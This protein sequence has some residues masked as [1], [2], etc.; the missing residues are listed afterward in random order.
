MELLIVRHGETIWNAKGLL[1]GQ[2]DIELNEN[3]IAAAKKLG[4]ELKDLKID[5]FFASPLKRA[6]ETAR[7][8]KG[9]R[10]L[11]IETD[12]R[13]KEISFGKAEGVDYHDWKEPGNKYYPFFEDTANYIP[14]EDGETFDDIIKRTTEFIKERIEP[15]HKTCERVLL[16]AHG[17]LNKGMMCYLEN[18]G[19]EKFW[20]DGLQMNCQAVVFDYDGKNWT[21]KSKRDGG[22]DE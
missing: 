15:L 22:R 2:T 13:L 14:P 3:G 8:I 16:V 4:D 9:T 19:P 10:T 21:L 7:L 17:A 12:S 18:H 5:R 20:G 1:Q 6:Y 11:D